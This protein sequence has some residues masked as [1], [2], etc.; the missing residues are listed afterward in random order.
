MFPVKSGPLSLMFDSLVMEAATRSLM[1]PAMTVN[2]GHTDC[3]T[4]KE[5]CQI[6]ERRLS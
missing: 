2:L 4:G 1:E 3:T 5:S 6:E